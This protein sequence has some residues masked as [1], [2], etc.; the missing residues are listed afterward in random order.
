MKK[1]KK[2]DKRICFAIPGW[3]TKH[4]GGAELQVYLISEEL[5]RR[6]WKVEVV[7]YR[8]NDKSQINN[9]FLNPDVNYYYYTKTKSSIFSILKAFRALIRTKSKIYY[10]RT[11]AL[12][13]K[14]ALRL[15]R[16]IKNIKLVYA[17]AHDIDAENLS[18]RD[19]FFS[20]NIFRKLDLY[21]ADILN[22]NSIKM[23]DKI[24]C[25]TED[26]KNILKAKTRQ[27]GEVIYNSF[28]GED[29]QLSKNN[30]I[31]WIGNMRGFKN[32]EA[33]FEILSMVNLKD[34][35]FYII[36]RNN[37]YIE[38]IKEFKDERIQFLGEMPYEE[39]IAY[40]KSAKI[41]INTSFSEGFSNTFIQAWFYGVWIE[42][43]N[44]NPDSILSSNGYG[45]FY[46]NNLKEL[47]KSTQ[48]IIDGKLEIKQ[49][50]VDSAKNFAKDKFDLVKNVNRLENLI[51]EF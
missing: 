40:F 51:L 46:N 8:P 29:V 5:I 17:L 42:S 49:D 16:I 20:N 34:W 10:F 36:G 3:V 35:K 1:E 33:L 50:L 41:L 44:V 13:L 6:G 14:V 11:D 38:Q 12:A 19:T 30:T 18:F 23:F 4:T 9:R 37:E 28:N 32:P 47:T 26:Q 39:T 43:L 21:F 22:H 7:T 15:L 2:P 24:V 45:R 31:L 48:D 27:E 25:Q